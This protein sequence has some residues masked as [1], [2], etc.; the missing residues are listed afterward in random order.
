MRSGLLKFV[1]VLWVGVLAGFLPS[2]C[3]E[4]QSPAVVGTETAAPSNPDRICA[5]EAGVADQSAAIRRRR[6]RADNGWMLVS[7][8]LVFDEWWPG[9]ALFYGESCVRRMSGH[10]MQTFAIWRDHSPVGASDLFVGLWE[11]QRVYRGLHKAFCRCGVGA[12][13]EY[14]ATIRCRRS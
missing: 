10:D 13:Q 7:A 12:G 11:R 6:Q 2:V 9:L 14:A 1:L 4:A 3:G 8:A 5:G